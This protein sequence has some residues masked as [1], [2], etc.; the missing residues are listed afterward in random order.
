MAKNRSVKQMIANEKVKQAKN[1][2][3]ENREARKAD[4]GPTWVGCAPKTQ[5][6][7][8][9]KSNRRCVRNRVDKKMFAEHLG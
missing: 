5:A 4:R 8:K 3:R 2:G 6:S 7:D 9:D 1:P